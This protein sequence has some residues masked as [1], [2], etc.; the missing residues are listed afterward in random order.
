MGK[1]K[2]KE[3][4]RVFT[5]QTAKDPQEKKKEYNNKSDQI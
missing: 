4:P 1:K 2:R 3:L 5:V